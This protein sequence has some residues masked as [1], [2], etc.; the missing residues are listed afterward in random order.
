MRVLILIVAALTLSSC[1][2]EKRKLGEGM[3]THA[4]LG[5]IDL[6][7]RESEHKLCKKQ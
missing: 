3:V 4:P 7:A 6:C 2:A 5:H 1:M